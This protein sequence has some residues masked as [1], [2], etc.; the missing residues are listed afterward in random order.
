LT[1]KLLTSNTGDS[2]PMGMRLTARFALA[3]RATS[4]SVVSLN[5]VCTPGTPSAAC[6]A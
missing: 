5:T 2:D 6:A 4:R 3:S 1:V